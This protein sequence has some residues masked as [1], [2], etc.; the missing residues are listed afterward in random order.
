M[1]V[2]FSALKF[3]SNDKPIKV[4]FLKSKI[5]TS[6]IELNTF[7]I[8]LIATKLLFLIDYAFSTSENAPSPYLFTSLYSISNQ[9]KNQIYNSF[10]LI[11]INNLKILKN[12]F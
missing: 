7:F 1:A 12:V 2:I 5:F 11:L 10:L 8:H 6:S 3:L 9:N 4:S